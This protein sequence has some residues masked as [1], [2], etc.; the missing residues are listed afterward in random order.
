MA[1]CAII[2]SRHQRMGYRLKIFLCGVAGFSIKVIEFFIK[3]VSENNSD[4]NILQYAI[5]II[6][7]FVC[8]V[9][10]FANRSSNRTKHI[11]KQKHNPDT[12]LRSK[13]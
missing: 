9:Y 8:I 13:C 11:Q 5:P 3:S 2:K 4:L 6:I 1:I 10:L 12:I 7:C